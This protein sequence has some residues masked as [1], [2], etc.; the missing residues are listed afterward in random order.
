VLK[1]LSYPEKSGVN[2]TTTGQMGWWDQESFT[3]FCW[4]S[5]LRALPLDIRW[6]HKLSSERSYSSLHLLP[7]HTYFGRPA[8]WS[9]VVGVVEIMTLCPHRK[10]DSPSLRWCKSRLRRLCS[11]TRI[12]S[13]R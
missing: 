5:S 3:L 7:T 10:G 6:S 9:E 4:A 12:Q 13:S 1:S 8:K 11:A 2:S